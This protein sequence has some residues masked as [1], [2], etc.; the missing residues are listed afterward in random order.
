[1]EGKRVRFHFMA[2]LEDY[3]MFGSE[4][5]SIKLESTGESSVICSYPFCV[6]VPSDLFDVTVYDSLIPNWN[7]GRF[8]VSLVLS[9]IIIKRYCGKLVCGKTFHY[10]KKCPSFSV[11]I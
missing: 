10:V 7:H 6:V 8:P 11:R 4:S 9:F 3:R 5:R 1:M 2:V